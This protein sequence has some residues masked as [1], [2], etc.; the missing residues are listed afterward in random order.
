VAGNEGPGHEG[1][2]NSGFVRRTVTVPHRNPI[3]EGKSN[4]N[5]EQQIVDEEFSYLEQCLHRCRDEV[6]REIITKKGQGGKFLDI[7]HPFLREGAEEL[8]RDNNHVLTFLQ[9]IED[10][11]GIQPV[12]PANFNP[13]EKQCKVQPTDFYC[14]LEWL[15]TSL[16]EAYLG[17]LSETQKNKA[18]QDMDQKNSLI[19][20]LEA[21]GLKVDKKGPNSATGKVR[22]PWPPYVLNKDGEEVA[23]PKVQGRYVYGLSMWRPLKTKAEDYDLLLQ[24]PWEKGYVRPLNVTDQFNDNED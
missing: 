21:K 1:D 16:W 15:K 13:C 20:A 2:Q 17:T 22:R 12:Q 9:M 11:G 4:K 19:N 14:H 18:R 7:L 10:D 24:R 6:E 23:G 5:L 3:T 8:H